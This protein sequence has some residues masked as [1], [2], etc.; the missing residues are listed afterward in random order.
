[1]VIRAFLM[2][3]QFE[4]LESNPDSVPRCSREV[5]YAIFPSWIVIGVIG[6]TNCA[7]W[8]R[9][10]VF[11][12]SFFAIFTVFVKSETVVAGANIGTQGVEA[13]VLTTS[14]VYCTFIHIWNKDVILIVNATRDPRFHSL[15]KAKSI[16]KN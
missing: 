3:F 1:M 5:P 7:K 16:F 4:F 6:A 9:N 14:M 12:I 10:F 2:G 8:Y 15:E 13:V 11:T